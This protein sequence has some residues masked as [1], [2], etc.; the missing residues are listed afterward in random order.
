MANQSHQN[1][2]SAAPAATSDGGRR[3]INDLPVEMLTNILENINLNIL[4]HHDK[5]ITKALRVCKLWRAI[6]EPIMWTNGSLRCHTESM[7]RFHFSE[8]HCISRVSA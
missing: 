7:V 5:G 3:N 6:V 4:E 8:S 2:S 1:I